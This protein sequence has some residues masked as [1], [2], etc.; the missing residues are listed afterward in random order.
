MYNLPHQIGI[1]VSVLTLAIV[2]SSSVLA[3]PQIRSKVIVTSQLTRKVAV[4]DNISPQPTEAILANVRLK[5]SIQAKTNRVTRPKVVN[6]RSVTH[7][8]ADR[9]SSGISTFTNVDRVNSPAN[10]SSAI[11]GFVD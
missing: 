10:N 4:M 7:I 8:S 6:P 5:A 2:S 3:K 1:A 11:D 9:S